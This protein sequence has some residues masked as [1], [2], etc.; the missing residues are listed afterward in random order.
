MGTWG[1]LL[2]ELT[3]LQRKIELAGAVSPPTPGDPSAHDI[4]RR[5]YLKALSEK[6]GRAT[7]VYAT[8]WLDA[9]DGVTGRDVSV[10]LG[11]VQGFME[12]VSNIDERNLDLILSSPGGSPEAAEAIM[13]YLR[14]RFDHIRAVIPLA[15][16]SAAT[17]M[18]L[19]CDEILMG[20]HS[21]LGPIDPQLSV[22]T[23]EGPRSAPGQAI[24]D[25]FEMAKK[26]CALEPSAIA[27]WLPI[28]RMFGPGLL[29]TCDNARALSEDFALRNLEQYMFVGDPEAK[30]KAA[31]V[32]AWFADFA[33][34][35][36]HGRRVSRED[37]RNQGLN[38][39]DL[40]SD[41]E[42]QD[43]V[44]SV[45]HAVAH[46]LSG[47]ACVKLIENHH[48][49]AWVKSKSQVFVQQVQTPPG[50]GHAPTPPV[51]P[52]PPGLA[53]VPGGNRAQRRAEQ[54][55]KT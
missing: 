37:V 25:Q 33:S 9:K 13:A 48:G 41:D 29:A 45:H 3:E 44:L 31:A 24:I 40:E 6:T 14:T 4:L 23:P 19:A 12:A 8:A 22:M 53:Q 42:L 39:T 36:S 51:Q 30:A 28:L 15:A 50:A 54:R 46:T 49:R 16:M 17:M 34:F 18:A 43:A 27:A 2:T 38:V 20:A 26:Q 52:S 10:E 5:V 1:E 11:D 32:A 47:T 35:K 55:K 21:G 7:I